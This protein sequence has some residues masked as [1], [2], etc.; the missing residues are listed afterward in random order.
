[1]SEAERTSMQKSRGKRVSVSI[2]G[3]ASS[4]SGWNGGAVGQEPRLEME[5]EAL[6]A[7]VEN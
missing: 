4:K 5:V 6:S 3:S 1:M 2:Q 7:T